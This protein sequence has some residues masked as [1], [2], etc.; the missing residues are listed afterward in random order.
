VN[1]KISG[2]PS[3]FPLPRFANDNGRRGMTLRD[4]FAGQA[5]VAIAS[6]DLREPGKYDGAIF[7][8]NAYEIADAMLKE[9]KK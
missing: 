3:A 2:N 9:R 5:M 6:S 8:R 7:A 4:W 1:D